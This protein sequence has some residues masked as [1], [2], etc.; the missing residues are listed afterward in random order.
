MTEIEPFYRIHDLHPTATGY[1][2]ATA[3]SSVKYKFS[4]AQKQQHKSINCVEIL[5]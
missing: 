3:P 1:F 2:P 5:K 4:A